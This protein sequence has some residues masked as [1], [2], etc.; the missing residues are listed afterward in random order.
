[1]MD[2][3]LVAVTPCRGRLSSAVFSQIM[4]VQL[5]VSHDGRYR[6]EPY[7]FSDL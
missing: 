2:A 6:Q 5:A 7:G 3:M 1:M 4:H